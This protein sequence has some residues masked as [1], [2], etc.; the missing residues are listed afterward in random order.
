M[1]WSKMCGESGENGRGGAESGREARARARARGEDTEKENLNKRKGLVGGDRMEKRFASS[2]DG[3]TL[4]SQGQGK[5]NAKENGKR[6]ETSSTSQMRRIRK[7]CGY[8]T[9]E[10]NGEGEYAGIL[11]RWDPTPGCETGIR[12]RIS[13]TDRSLYQVGEKVL[14]EHR[15]GHNSA[16]VVKQIVNE[17][18]F[19]HLSS[20]SA[21]THCDR[22]AF[23]FSNT[24]QC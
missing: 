6:S 4:L 12:W 20:S 15:S 1:G 11:R 21:Y 9:K 24:H 5:R 23:M 17:D 8:V 18:M 2:S 19:V 14:V 10:P 3:D 22:N 16:R 7:Q 13:Q